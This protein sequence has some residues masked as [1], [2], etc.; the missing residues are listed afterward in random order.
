[1]KVLIFCMAMIGGSV[2]KH[3]E[4]WPAGSSNDLSHSSVCYTQWFDRDNPTGVGD[5]ETLTDL[6]AENPGLICSNPLT[7]QAVTLSGVP[8]QSIGQVFQWYDVVNGFGCANTEQHNGEC[9][10]DYKVRFGCPCT[11]G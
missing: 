3:D 5:Y 1:M 8:A 2:G 10:L 9:C 7:I 4:H 11:G 6:R